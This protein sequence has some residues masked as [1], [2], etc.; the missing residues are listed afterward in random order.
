MASFVPKTTQKWS[1]R[2]YQ[3]E[4]KRLPKSKLDYTNRSHIFGKMYENKN[5]NLLSKNTCTCKSINATKKNH[6]NMEIVTENIYK[7]TEK[8]TLSEIYN[9]TQ[10]IYEI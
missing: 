10:R 9:S 2:G 7:F 6:D 3:T 5:K 1:G 8:N 4:I